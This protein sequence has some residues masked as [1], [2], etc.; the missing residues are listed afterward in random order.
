MATGSA[1]PAKNDVAQLGQPVQLSALQAQL[2]QRV[3]QRAWAQQLVG[4]TRRAVAGPHPVAWELRLAGM[5]V[6]L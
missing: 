5:T 6:L 4:A 3:L 1:A 2:E